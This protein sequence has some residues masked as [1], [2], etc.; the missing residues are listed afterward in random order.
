[1]V[2]QRIGTSW[3]L[4][5]STDS[6]ACTMPAGMLAVGGATAT[7]LTATLSIS[8]RSAVVPWRGRPVTTC[9]GR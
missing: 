6:V 2:S 7:L 8:P 3:M 9:A 5:T 1:M 4:R